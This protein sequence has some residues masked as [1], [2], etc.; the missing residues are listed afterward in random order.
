MTE[1]EKVSQKESLLL[2]NSQ[3]AFSKSCSSPITPYRNSDVDFHDVFGGP[4]RR[5]SSI[6]DL[7]YDSNDSKNSVESKGDDE[8]LFG[9]SNDKPVFGDETLNRRRYPSKDFF[10]DI[11]RV[12]ESVS[13]A[14]RK[15]E[16]DPFSSSPGSRV[17]S[18]ARPLQP[19]KSETSAQL[20]FLI[21]SFRRII[22]ILFMALWKL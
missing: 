21:C 15:L 1:M 2:G 13:S 19:L 20:R 8:P 10:D 16:R 17:L 14:P 4:P 7:G 3:R 11:F 18:P 22:I 6:H 9:L 12:N 5:R